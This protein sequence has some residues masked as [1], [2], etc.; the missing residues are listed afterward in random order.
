M[1]EVFF[2]LSGI[3]LH[4]PCCSPLTKSVKVRL[5]SLGILWVVESSIHDT[6]PAFT[7]V[8]DLL[9]VTYKFHPLYNLPWMDLFNC[10]LSHVWHSTVL[11]MFIVDNLI[12]SSFYSA[13]NGRNGDYCRQQQWESRHFGNHVG[14]YFSCTSY[15]MII[16][17][18]IAQ[19]L[20]FD[21]S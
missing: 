17:I 9:C 19:K 10:T 12:V 21:T 4:L 13:W 2:L 14:I 15:W 16:N 1:M 7:S 20:L 8:H 18:N 11:A 6:Y 3:K 5:Y